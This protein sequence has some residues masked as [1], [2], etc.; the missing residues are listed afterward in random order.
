MLGNPLLGKSEVIGKS[1]TRGLILHPI[2]AF[3][4]LIAWVLC[5][6]DKLKMALFASLLSFLAA[7]LTLLAFAID[8]AL[9]VH[10]KNVIDK[11]DVGAKT[12]PGPAFWMS[13]IVLVL[14]TVSGCLVCFGWRRTKSKESTYVVGEK[15]PWYQLPLWKKH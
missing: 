8:I 1:W 9:Y 7:F 5:F 15:K 6:S 11:I 10:V 14:V 3:V 12:S 4:T 13:L 2:A